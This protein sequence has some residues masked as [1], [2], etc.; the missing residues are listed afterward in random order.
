MRFKSGDLAMCAEMSPNSIHAYCKQGLLALVTP[1]KKNH[2]DFD[3]RQIPQ[4]YLIRLLRELGLSS[5][6]ILEY[7]QNRTPKSA[8]LL[9]Q[10]YGGRLADEIAAR[11]AELDILYS[12][13]WLIEEGLATEAGR[14]ELRAL[15][16]RTIRLSALKSNGT[17]TKNLEYLRFA[18][19]EIRLQG[20]PG[21]PLGVYYHTF[22]GLLEKPDRPAQLV[23]FDPQGPDA[24]PAGEYLVGT[25]AGYY[26]EQDGLARRMTGFAQ[27]N[28]LELCGPVCAVYLYDAAA[29]KDPKQY[30]QQISAA[31]KR[32]EDK[33]P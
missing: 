31:V 33:N 29:V 15:P 9:L 8:L 20:N 13:T 3:A 28:G 18:C 27:E 6:E 22:A 17:L 1:T 32:Q 5:E 2:L 10:K 25:A 26:G 21:C 12:H 19:R 11:Q 7:G 30:L 14:I 4:L 23:S 16:A 24:L